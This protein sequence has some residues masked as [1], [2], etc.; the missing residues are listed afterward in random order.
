MATELTVALNS[1]S[2]FKAALTFN[3]LNLGLCNQQPRNRQAELVEHTFIYP[4]VKRG[5]QISCIVRITTM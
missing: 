2:S 4:T 5:A 3:L 1:W